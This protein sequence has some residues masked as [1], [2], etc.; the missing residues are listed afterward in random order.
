MSNEATQMPSMV[1]L[2][3]MFQGRHDLIR[4]AIVALKS[5]GAPVTLDTCHAVMVGGIRS[6]A[7]MV[8]WTPAGYCGG[9][10]AFGLL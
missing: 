3:N 5:A 2:E 9:R 8:D 4:A 10:R 1:Q 6:A 7:E